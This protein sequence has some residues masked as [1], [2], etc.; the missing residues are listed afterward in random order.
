MTVEGLV[1]DGKQEAKELPGQITVFVLLSPTMK[2][3][4]DLAP[5]VRQ[6]GFALADFSERHMMHSFP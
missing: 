2:L 1:V 3:I 4:N 6:C 5:G